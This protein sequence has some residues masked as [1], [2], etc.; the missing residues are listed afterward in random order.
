MDY[1]SKNARTKMFR[2]LKILEYDP[3]KTEDFQRGEH[4]RETKFR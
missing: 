3:G 2:N 1:R 4:S